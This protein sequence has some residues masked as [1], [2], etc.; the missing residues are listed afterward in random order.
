M[1]G[2]GREID[3]DHKHYKE[4]N[5]RS[6]GGPEIYFIFHKRQG[7]DPLL[8]HFASFITQ[9]F[10]LSFGHSIGNHYYFKPQLIML[11]TYYSYN[12]IFKTVLSLNA[13]CGILFSDTPFS[14]LIKP[15][16]QHYISPPSSCLLR[17]GKGNPA[18]GV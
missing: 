3:H 15:D 18:L 12:G 4:T 14:V 9:L 2:D 6:F 16:I 11:L 13:C 5:L 7:W 8:I 1:K 17:I 10:N